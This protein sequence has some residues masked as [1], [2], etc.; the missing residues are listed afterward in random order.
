MH[1]IADNDNPFRFEEW[2]SLLE[3]QGVKPDCGPKSRAA[4][5]STAP[6]DSPTA[7]GPDQAKTSAALPAIQMILGLDVVTF[8]ASNFRE[9]VKRLSSSVRELERTR[10][11]LVN[12]G[13]IKEVW[14]GK[15][16]YLAPEEKLY[17]LLAM[18]C[19]Y[20][21]NRWDLHSFLI[22]L[23]TKLIEP[24]PLVKYVKPEVS[25]GDSNATVD[26]IVY[27]KNGNR[28]AY[29]I[30]HKGV[31]NVSAN[32]AKLQGKGFSQVVFLCMDFNVKQRVWALIRNAGF[33][34]NFLSTIRCQ[35]FSALIRQRNQ[36]M[37]K[38]M[39]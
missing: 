7:K 11:A 9:R 20:K 26:L 38:E 27:L 3:P 1:R 19:P 5:K 12:K 32:A 24:N 37:L 2:K 18:D 17:H 16:L 14:L 10:Q 30:I 25:L 15:S 13:L 28:W 21:R 22:L 6:A 29:E 39:K 4:D 35:I 34:S 23:A 8:L 31:T 33:H 36:L